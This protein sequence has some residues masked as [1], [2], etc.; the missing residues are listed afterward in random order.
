[1]AAGD[2]PNPMFQEE[3]RQ[4]DGAS[5]C[6]KHP[7]E[8]PV[9]QNEVEGVHGD[10]LDT[11]PDAIQNWNPGLGGKGDTRVSVGEP[12]I[13][14]GHLLPWDFMPLPEDV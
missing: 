10:Q 14:I 4:T 8:L 9:Y 6:L 5:C 3:V 1:M 12:S 13:P 7:G 2:T 11:V